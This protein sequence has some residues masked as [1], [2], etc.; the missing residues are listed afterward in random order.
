MR[1]SSCLFT[2]PLP[3]P[4]SKSS[5]HPQEPAQTTSTCRGRLYSSGHS[6]QHYMPADRIP[7]DTAHRTTFLPLA[8][9]LLFQYTP[10][11]QSALSE[12]K[13]QRKASMLFTIRY[14]LR[15][16]QR[17]KHTNKCVFDLKNGSTFE[18]VSSILR[19]L[20]CGVKS[21]AKIYWVDGRQTNMECI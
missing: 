11:Y 17:D 20:F 8:A 9:L 5:S 21:V 7:R 12:F 6:T 16:Q 2:Y 13:P 18:E 4:L 14:L 15:H 10:R 3:F 19:G 1:N